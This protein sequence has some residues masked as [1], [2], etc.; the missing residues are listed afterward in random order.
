MLSPEMSCIKILYS[1]GIKAK[2]LSSKQENYSKF[3]KLFKLC[4]SR[5]QQHC[6]L[7]KASNF[8]LL[9]FCAD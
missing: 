9:L 1:Q 3:E 6:G 7:V 8:V 4:G 2:C 5:P